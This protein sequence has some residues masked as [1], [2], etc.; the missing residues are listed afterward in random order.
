LAAN[1]FTFSQITGYEKKNGSASY[2]YEVF[3][4]SLMHKTK[5][6]KVCS[7]VAFFLYYFLVD[8][9]DKIGKILITEQSDSFLPPKNP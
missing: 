1:K 4:S 9:P 8:I 3:G 2:R 7:L 5:A 6:T